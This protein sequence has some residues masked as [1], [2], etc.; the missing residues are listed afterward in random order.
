MTLEEIRK[1]L[2]IF[3]QCAL[4]QVEAAVEEWVDKYCEDND[5]NFTDI[6]P[7]T[8]KEALLEDDDFIEEVANAMVM[9]AQ[10]K[11]IND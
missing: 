2:R 8:I 4:G 9:L 1:N 6:N 7:E 11:M 3:K 5:P 10:I